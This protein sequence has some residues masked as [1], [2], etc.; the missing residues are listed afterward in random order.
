MPIIPETLTA[1]YR[2]NNKKL[3]HVEKVSQTN[4]SHSHDVADGGDVCDADIVGANL[5][6]HHGCWRKPV[7]LRCIGHTVRL[8]AEYRLLS[9]QS[10]TAIK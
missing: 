6:L 9:Q 4:R 8:A 2:R 10:R 3:L 1:S 5:S 7:W